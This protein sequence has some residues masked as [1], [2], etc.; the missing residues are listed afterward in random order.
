MPPVSMLADQLFSV[1]EVESSE[2][3]RLRH[4][5]LQIKKASLRWAVLEWALASAWSPEIF[6]MTESP[7]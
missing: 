5:S 7:S 4:C 3:S 2:S 1:C 6:M